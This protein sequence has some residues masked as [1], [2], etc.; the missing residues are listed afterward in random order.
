MAMYVWQTRMRIK[1]SLNKTASNKAFKS[2]TEI[3]NNDDKKSTPEI[4]IPAEK[5][6][7]SKK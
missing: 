7:R 5:E 1:N 6:Q 2:K 4:K 3:I